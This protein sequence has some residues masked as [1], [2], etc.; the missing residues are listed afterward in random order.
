M[1]AKVGCCMGS[2]PCSLGRGV[3]EGGV[4]RRAGLT[5]SPAASLELWR[6]GAEVVE[7]ARDE[8]V[9]G[10]GGAA[11]RG[12]AAARRIAVPLVGEPV[13]DGEERVVEDVEVDV[14]QSAGHRAGGGLC[15]V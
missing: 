4:A 3:A 12:A 15:V 6:A 10:R 11:D 5:C 14:P 8:P 9:V 13:D 2:R 7:A 1:T